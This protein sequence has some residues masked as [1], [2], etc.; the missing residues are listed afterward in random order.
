[1]FQ[2]ELKSNI[3]SLAVLGLRVRSAAGEVA[4]LNPWVGDRSQP[5]RLTR[6]VTRVNRTRPLIVTQELL[7]DLMLRSSFHKQH[8][9]VS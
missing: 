6:S 2:R 4:R 5:V 7:Y 9:P 8:P 1:M 3:I